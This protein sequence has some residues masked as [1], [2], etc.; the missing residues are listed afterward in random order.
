MCNGDGEL[1]IGSAPELEGIPKGVLDAH[2]EVAEATRA[3]VAHR[4][5]AP[6]IARCRRCGAG[7]RV[8]DIEVT[9]A[10][11][12]SCAA[13]HVIYRAKRAPR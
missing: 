8:A 13:G 12:V 9:G 6:I 7:L 2:P 11:V 10:L 4:N 3:I 1:Q 5:G